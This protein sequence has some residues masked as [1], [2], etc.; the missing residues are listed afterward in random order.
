[1]T[2]LEPGLTARIARF[3][4]TA[5]GANFPESA[6][7]F[8]RL[9][10]LDW[11]SVTCAGLDEPVSII[12]RAMLAAEGG[13]PES[14]VLGLADRLPARA[15]AL[16]NGTTSH[17]LDYD[18][19][20]FDYI[21]HVAVAI[22]PAVLALA[23][24]VGASGKT[25]MEAFLVGAESACRLGR[26]FGS[27]HYQYG[28]HQ[29]ATSGAFGATAAASRL[30]GLSEEQT[31]HALGIA[32]TRASGLKSQFGTFGKPYHAGMA[33]STGVEAATL[34][35][36]GFISRPD[37]IECEQGF[38]ETHAAAGGDIPAIFADLGTI[39]RFERIQ[40]KYHACC[41]GT[42]APLEAL[43]AAREASNRPADAI[44]AVSLKVHPRWLRVCNIQSPATGLEAKFSFPLTAAMAL[45][46]VDTAALD[47]FVDA[48]CFRPDLVRL[49]N[50]VTVETDAS[51]GDTEALVRVSYGPDET[52]VR[53][54]DLDMPVA[55]SVQQQKLIAKARA[56]VGAKAADHLWSVIGNLELRPTT[57]LPAALQIAVRHAA[58]RAPRTTD[59][60]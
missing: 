34:A 4:A 38:A 49:R 51:F 50:N 56:L 25:L 6:F 47:T 8:A 18:D 44:T 22:F 21:G 59:M 24:K 45:A 7:A 13:T 46:H 48:M 11:C 27:T 39:F 60:P 58:E 3:A 19:T 57:D 30:L 12:V 32:A 26:Y 36:L 52:V 31:R 41:H 55:A 14:T 40:Y 20:H 42:H 2:Q 37:G 54:A 28:F 17:A 5:D 1:M 9:S 10:I 43:I 33:A 53:H 16:A 15:A 35:S 23:E 29:T